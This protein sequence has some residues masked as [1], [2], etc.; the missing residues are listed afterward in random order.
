MLRVGYPVPEIGSAGALGATLRDAGYEKER[1]LEALGVGLN[2]EL[3]E[4]MPVAHLRSGRLE[5]LAALFFAGGTVDEGA[6]ADA[7]APVT[8]AD[9]EAGALLARVPGGVRATVR[10]MEHDGLLIA[11]DR[12]DMYPA[13][14]Y[15]LEVG[16][17]TR[18]TTRFMIRRPADRGLDACAGNGLHALLLRGHVSHVV[19][20]DISERAIAFARFNE[21]LNGLDG[22]DWRIGNLLEPVDGETFGLIVSN[23][24]YAVEPGSGPIYRDGGTAADDVSRIVAVE[25]ARAL[26]EGGFATVCGN[27]IVRPGEKWYEPVERWLEESGCDLLVLRIAFEDPLAYASPWNADILEHEGEAAYI[28]AVERH[29]DYLVQLGAEAVAD[30]VVVMRK[31]E[32]GGWR[33]REDVTLPDKGSGSDQL[34][35]IFDA[36]DVLSSL[37]DERELLDLVLEPAPGALLRDTWRYEGAYRPSTAELVLDDE[38]GLDGQFPP[39]AVD[40]V[41][42]LDGRVSLRVALGD[43]ADEN[44]PAL[45]RLFA[46]GFLQRATAK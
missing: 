41:R 19:G 12:Q 31:R 21:A 1:Y 46:Q 10:V 36:E 26:E 24:P 44:L 35:R 43:S 8:L 28:A 32:R 17:A 29:R 39:A 14:D 3:R 22:I 38:I 2:V 40:A 6:A 18:A 34:L 37:D 23:P 13:H 4:A 11:S 45:R 25:A 20:T 33:R 30:G 42:R 9:L 5:T 7:V 15:V 27:W 16:P